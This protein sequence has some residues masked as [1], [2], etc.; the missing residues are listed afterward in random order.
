MSGLATSAF[1]TLPL[2]L[3]MYFSLYCQTTLLDHS[4]VVLTLVAG[5]LIIA[6]ARSASSLSKTGAPSPTGPPRTMQVTSP[7]HELPL[8]RTLSM[9]ARQH[10]GSVN[11]LCQHRPQG[12]GFR[13]AVDLAH[14]ASRHNSRQASGSSRG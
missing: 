11:I 13:A 9:A 14:A 10:D 4:H 5:R 12:L 7:P 6:F 8:V 2:K 3:L 1:D